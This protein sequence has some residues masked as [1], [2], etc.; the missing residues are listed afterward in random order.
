MIKGDRSDSIVLSEIILVRCIVSMPGNN[1]EWRMIIIYLEEFSLE[2]V[3][4]GPFF[5][6]IFIPSYRYLKVTRVC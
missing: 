1:I 4:N 2:F 5:L 3:Y 6:N